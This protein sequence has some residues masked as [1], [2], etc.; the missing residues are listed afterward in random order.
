M[1]TFFSELCL[2][3]RKPNLFEFFNL[4]KI[5]RVAT[6]FCDYQF[7]LYMFTYALTVDPVQ[8]G[9]HNYK[10]FIS[11]IFKNC[12]LKIGKYTCL[13]YFDPKYKYRISGFYYKL[14]HPVKLS[15]VTHTGIIL[16]SVSFHIHLCPLGATSMNII[17]EV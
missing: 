14:K 1:L 11:N 12:C 17:R 5:C 2:A 7:L 4:V 6:H 15:S 3:Q 9:I 8:T 13:F 16:L 10:L